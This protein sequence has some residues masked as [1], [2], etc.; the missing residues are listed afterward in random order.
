MFRC[1]LCLAWHL[2]IDELMAH[3][4]FQHTLNVLS[5]LSCA[6]EGCNRQFDTF[7]AF[8][9]HLR[10]SHVNVPQRLILPEVE[11]E[12]NDLNF[13]NG[14]NNLEININDLNDAANDNNVNDVDDN[15]LSEGNI[16]NLNE[17][18]PDEVTLEN[19]VQAV[20]RN[21][22]MFAAYLYSI[23]TLNRKNVELI[24]SGFSDFLG[25]GIVGVL[26]G[27]VIASLE[28]CTCENANA[29]N[30]FDIKGMFDVLE[31]PFEYMAS[32]FKRI[33]NFIEGGKFIKPESYVINYEN[34]FVRDAVDVDLEQKPVCVQVVPLIKSLKVYLEVPGMYRCMLD[35]VDSLNVQSDIVK[36]FLQAELWQEMLVKFEGKTVFP[37]FLHFDDYEPD[38]VLGSHAG[39]HKL[40]A[41]YA[42]IASLPSELRSVVLNMFM[43]ALFKSK[44]RKSAGNLNTFSCIIE[45]L[46]FLEEEGIVLELAT[47]NVRIYFVLCL[48]VA[49]NLGHNSIHGFVEGFSAFFY[50]RICKI[51]KDVAAHTLSAVEALRRTRHN[52]EID[53]AVNDSANWCKEGMCV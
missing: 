17:N 42:S 36:D 52:Y 8:R 21:A 26:K 23:P 47:G 40:G 18:A 44:D 12:D 5:T 25:F 41:V 10:N 20:Y 46:R 32:E 2:S 27:K 37:L 29:N 51:H 33:G 30:I 6:Q 28:E 53:V 50:C 9:K 48:I 14:D 24:I 35:H 13:E 3:F 45:E 4:Q 7:K 11:G 31:S 34:Q 38:N 1:F 39:D 16:E 43:V 22:E 15:L 19:F 49:D